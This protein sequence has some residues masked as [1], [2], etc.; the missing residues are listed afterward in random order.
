MGL[1][2]DRLQVGKSD[3]QTYSNGIHG[4]EEKAS[5]FLENLTTRAPVQDAMV[6][7][8][9]RKIRDTEDEKRKLMSSP[10]ESLV[11]CRIARANLYFSVQIFRPRTRS[12]E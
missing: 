4:V 7:D 10:S 11:R 2:D 3:V 1:M 9:E 6:D 5:G 8:I 12:F